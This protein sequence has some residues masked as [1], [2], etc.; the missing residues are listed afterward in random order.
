[1]YFLLVTQQDWNLLLI[2]FKPVQIR[3]NCIKIDD[4]NLVG[5]ENLDML[6]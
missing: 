5:S 2:S 1:M 4:V 6:F 3:S